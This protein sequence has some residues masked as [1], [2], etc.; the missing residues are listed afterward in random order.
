MSSTVESLDE[1]ETK[2]LL[3]TT[4]RPIGSVVPEF[5]QRDPQILGSEDKSVGIPTNPL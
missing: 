1:S 2:V 3:S 4:T 5:L